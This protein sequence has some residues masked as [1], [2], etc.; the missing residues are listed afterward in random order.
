M[1]KL[2]LTYG[3]DVH[4]SGGWGRGDRVRPRSWSELGRG[5]IFAV[6]TPLLLGGWSHG[7]CVLRGHLELLSVIWNDWN[8]DVHRFWI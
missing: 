3:E 7:A 6:G 8:V 2:Y 4:M 1:S 5:I